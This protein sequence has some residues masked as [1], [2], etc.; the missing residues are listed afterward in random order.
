MVRRKR[1]RRIASE[2]TLGGGLTIMYLSVGL[3]FVHISGLVYSQ[4]NPLLSEYLSPPFRKI[5][6]E[7]VHF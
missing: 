5:I 4:K 1:R 2:E 6:A 7:P 3:G